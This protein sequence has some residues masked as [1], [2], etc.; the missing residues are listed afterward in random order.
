M[1]KILDK[2]LERIKKS[3]QDGIL[4]R[5]VTKSTGRFLQILVLATRSKK[6]LELGCSAGY[7]TIWLAQA[8]KEFGGHVYTT[9]T[10]K[11]RIKIAKSNFEEAGL[12]EYI[13]LFEKDAVDVL[14]NWNLGEIDF[15]FIDAT[16]Q[17]YLKYY[18]LILP[19]LKSGGLVIADD[20]IK[21]K[22]LVEPFL[23]KVNNDS[24]VISQLLEDEHGLVLIYKK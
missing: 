4:L 11:P 22:N 12:S 16:K 3:E 19:L 5:P 13:T 23:K 21:F 15:A 7:S 9:E 2:I 6:I 10:S 1:N 14:S 18:E 24:R 8:A 17:D 20:V